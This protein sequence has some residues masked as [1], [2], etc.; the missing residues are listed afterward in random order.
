[1]VAA[2]NV[3]AL[4]LYRSAGMVTETVL[5]TVPGDPSSTPLRLLLA[6]G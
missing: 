3:A 5:R 1:E 2:D 4:A 6:R